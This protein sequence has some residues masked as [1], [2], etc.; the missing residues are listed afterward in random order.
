MF[1]LISEIGVNYYDIA[2]QRNISPMEAAKLM[3]NEAIDS[4]VHAVKF[5]TYKAGTLAVKNSPS[6]WDLT[7]EPTQSQYELFRK[8]DS[9]GEPEYAELSSYC[10][11]KGIEFLS[12]AFDFESADYLNSHMN[13]YKIS[14]SDLNNL[15]FI[16]YQ[17]AKGKPILLSCG[18][19]DSHEIN[20]AVAEIR[21]INR[22]PLVLLHCVLE[23][24]TPPEH[25]NL[26]KIASLKEQYPNLIIGYSDHTMPD[27]TKEIVK[28]A[29]LLGAVI[30]EKHFTLDKTIRGNDHYHAMDPADAQDIIKK[31]SGLDVICGS[32]DLTALETEAS[33]RR[34]ARRSIAS[35][36]AIVKGETITR[37]MLTFKR[38]GFGISP[39]DIEKLTDM[40]A[41]VDIDEDTILQWDMF[42]E[43]I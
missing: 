9:F 2:D 29:Y 1:T 23:Y 12:T 5:Q 18:A 40:R 20:M 38:P 16:R 11:E 36:A 19:S 31:I 17:A 34:N 14:S 15:P 3:I 6:Y 13:V 26:R 37:Q 33:A 21:K 10:A 30:V 43:R 24:P 22:Q 42:E 41:F 39:A 7:K 4:G 25:A 27:V 32:G 8:H 35:T 28:T